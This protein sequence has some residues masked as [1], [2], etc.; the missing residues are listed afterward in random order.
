MTGTIP[1][2]QRS[3][4]ALIRAPTL[5][6]QVQPLQTAFFLKE[7]GTSQHWTV[8]KRVVFCTHCCLSCCTVGGRIGWFRRKSRRQRDHRTSHVG[9]E[10]QESLNSTS[11]PAQTLHNPTLYLRE[12]S[13][14]SWSS[15]SFGAMTVPWGACSVPSH[16]VGEDFFPK[17]QPKSSL[18][19]LQ[20]SLRSCHC[21]TEQT[22]S[23]PSLLRKM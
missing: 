7:G 11:G 16:P 4:V 8:H 12:L 20:H 10:T 6:C 1:S 3:D 19:H 14:C 9:R 18:A 21:P 23:C 13:T 17:S 22:W 5:L 15:G 2:S